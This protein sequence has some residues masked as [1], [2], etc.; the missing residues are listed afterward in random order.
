MDMNQPY[1]YLLNIDTN[2]IKSDK[3]KNEAIKRKTESHD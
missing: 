2:K 1:L 3:S